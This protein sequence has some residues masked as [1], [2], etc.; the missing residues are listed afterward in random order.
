MIRLLR[1]FRVARGHL[2]QSAQAYLRRIG[3]LGFCTGSIALGCTSISS[4]MLVP[5]PDGSVTKKRAHGYPITVRVPTQLRVTIV[6]KT[7]LYAN[8]NAIKAILL[9][10][11]PIFIPDSEIQSLTYSKSKGFPLMPEFGGAIQL[12]SLPG[13][14][15]GCIKLFTYA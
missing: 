3:V 1:E 10:V 12:A 11:L 15:T 4:E 7:Y 6:E 14:V 8:K 9:I 5:N 13:S 2:P